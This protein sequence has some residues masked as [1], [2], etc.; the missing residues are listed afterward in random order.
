MLRTCSAPAIDPPMDPCSAALSQNLPASD[1][2]PLCHSSVRIGALASRAAS[3]AAC[4]VGDP[5]TLT[6]GSAH[7]ASLQYANSS[8]SALPVTTPG[9]SFSVA[10]WVCACP[11]TDRG[12]AGGVDRV[13]ARRCDRK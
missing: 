6:A 11:T 8:C 7:F 2:E 10:M 13:A 4:A 9:F 3:I 1:A 5:I 12:H